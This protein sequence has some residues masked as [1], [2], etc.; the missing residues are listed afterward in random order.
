MGAAAVADI[1]AAVRVADIRAAVREVDIRAAVVPVVVI[2][3]AD[4]G[5]ANP[6]VAAI[7]KMSSCSAAW[8]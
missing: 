1:R 6:A 4:R 3:A 7:V 2:R 8:V 5:A